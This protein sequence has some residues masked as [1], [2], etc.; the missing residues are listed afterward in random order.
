MKKIFLTIS[1]LLATQFAQ[2][3]QSVGNFFL[4]VQT[5][6]AYVP[7][8]GATNLTSSI[9]WDDENFKFP[10]GFPFNIDGKVVNDFAFS[11][12]EGFGP[13]SDTI[14]IVNTFANFSGSDLVDRGGLGTVP[15][16]PLR[17]ATVGVS[18]NRIFKFEVFNAGFFDEMDIYSTLDDS[19]NFQIW[20]YETSNIVEFRF[21]ASKISN[22]LDY[23]YLGG[24]PLIGYVSDFDLS[25]STFPKAYTLI[26]NPNNPDIDSFVDLSTSPPVLT[27]FPNYGTVYRFIPKAAAAS[28]GETSIAGQFKVY[29]TYTTDNITVVATNNAATTA[30]IIDQNGKLVSII[31]NIQKGANSIDVSHFA[32]GN[33]VLEMANAE[34]KAIYK[35]TKQ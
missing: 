9:I 22:P 17:Y 13:A 28:I 8:T 34:G 18:P 12:G 25:N 35:F 16:S 1:V 31:E 15:L 27:S 11:A 29:P 26:G 2:A 24:S 33:Y 19:V 10:I 30:R 6:Q 14:G 7:L 32:S 20:L 23:F 4:K 5:G 21:G 3:Q